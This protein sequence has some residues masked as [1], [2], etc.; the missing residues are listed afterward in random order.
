MTEPIITITNDIQFFI[1]AIAR[2]KISIKDDITLN[3]YKNGLEV[4]IE[5]RV[6]FSRRIAIGFTDEMI[7][8]C[9]C[10]L[11]LRAFKYLSELPIKS[12]SIYMNNTDLLTF[13]WKT[14]TVDVVMRVELGKFEETQKLN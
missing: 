10:P 1:R 14:E 7:F 3:I 6:G 2:L 4:V 11:D 9:H 5:N 12:L 8:S 13:I